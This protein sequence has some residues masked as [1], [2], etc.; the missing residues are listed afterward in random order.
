M[1]GERQPFFAVGNCDWVGRGNRE[2]AVE[3]EELGE[4]GQVQRQE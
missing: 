1:E 3:R 2:G 4:G